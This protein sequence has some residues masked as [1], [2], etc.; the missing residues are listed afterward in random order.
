[1]PAIVRVAEHE[2]NDRLREL[3]TPRKALL[4]VVRGAVAAFAECT[5]DDPPGAAGYETYRGGTRDLRYHLRRQKSGWQIDNEG[6]LASSRNDKVGIRLIVLNT[7]DATGDPDPARNPKNRRK[8]GVLHERA[9]EGESMWFSGF[10]PEE[11]VS[12]RPWYLCLCISDAKVLAELS[13]PSAMIGGYIT[14]WEERIIL[15]SP[16]EWDR[17][18]FD[19]V[20]SDDGPEPEILVRR[21]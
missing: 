1:M 10:E 21:K 11:R 3:R 6:N 13:R 15:I 4:E 2:V 16:G 5:G 20:D 17:I 7:D 9:I 19:D 8:K 18:R 12:H 14:S